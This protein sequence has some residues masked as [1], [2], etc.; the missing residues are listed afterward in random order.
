MK[1]EADKVL[2]LGRKNP[3]QRRI[4]GTDCQG[5]CSAGKDPVVFVGTEL[6]MSQVCPGSKDDQQH[7]GLY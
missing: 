7:P 4:L 6:N 5:N 1:L 3:L 2:H